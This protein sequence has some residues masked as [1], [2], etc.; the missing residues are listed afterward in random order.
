M[1]KPGTPDE[2]WMNRFYAVANRV[3]I[4]HGLVDKLVGDEVIARLLRLAPP[5][6]AAAG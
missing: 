3:I 2:N 6:A 4:D 5:P 1:G